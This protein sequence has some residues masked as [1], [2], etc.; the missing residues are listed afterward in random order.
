MLFLSSAKVDKICEKSL[1]I[2][3]FLSKNMPFLPVAS[4]QFPV[5]NWFILNKKMQFCAHEKALCIDRMRAYWP[6]TRS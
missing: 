6:A 3:S 5:Q 4:A 1:I 2:C